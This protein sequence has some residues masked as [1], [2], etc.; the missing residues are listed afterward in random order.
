MV[1]DCSVTD[2][3]IALL[4]TLSVKPAI[5]FYFFA[6]PVQL[7]H[8]NSLGWGLRGL[9]VHYKQY[10][11]FNLSSA[12][13]IQLIIFHLLFKKCSDVTTQCCCAYIEHCPFPNYCNLNY[14][15]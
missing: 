3:G 10:K 2:N 8:N 9:C 11:Q 6:K 5:L 4:V 7:V 1:T 13:L 14:P 15:H 12:V